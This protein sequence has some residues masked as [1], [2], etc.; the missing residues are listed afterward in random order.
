M[1]HLCPGGDLQAALAPYRAL[2][3]QVDRLTARI[4]TEFTGQIECRDGCAS[5]CTLQGVLPVEAASLALAWRE[6][7]A[8]R[9]ARL[10]TQLHAADSRDRCPLLID[11]R[12]PLYAARPI[13]CRTHGLP[14]LVEDPAGTRVDRCP[15][16]F[17]GL[18]TLP[19]TAVIHLD[20]LN[21]ALVAA[22]HHFLAT[23][24]VPGSIAARIPLRQIP[25][26]PAVDLD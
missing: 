6:L 22:N 14:L 3:D 1:K 19:G 10:R 21:S 24:F 16:N 4:V 2:L 18:T 8:T 5:C 20:R 23:C 26:F 17:S 11:D 13:I 7:S 25:T 9:A 12:C 15:L